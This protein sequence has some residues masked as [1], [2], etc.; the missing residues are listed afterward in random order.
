MSLIEYTV[1][2]RLA[3]LLRA[4][5]VKTGDY[6]AVFMTNSPEMVVTMYALAKLGA[7]AALV[8]TNLRGMESVF[9]S[10]VLMLMAIRRHIRT[11]SQC[12]NCQVNHLNSRP[13]AI[14]IL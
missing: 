5:D 4:R 10:D 14:C 9:F 12:L 7:V 11:L 6:V 3:A 13:D 8:N 1:V 2:D